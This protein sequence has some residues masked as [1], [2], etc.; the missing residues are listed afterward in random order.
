M[1]QLCN[2]VLFAGAR[3]CATNYYCLPAPVIVC[4]KL[5]LFAR[6]SYCVLQTSIV[7]QGQLLSATN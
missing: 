7:C 3:Y 1:K 4:Y 2:V 5:V 6:V